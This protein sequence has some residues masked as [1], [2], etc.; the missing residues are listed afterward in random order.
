MKPNDILGYQSKCKSIKN[1]VKAAA[2]NQLFQFYFL[3]EKNN[4]LTQISAGFFFE[5]YISWNNEF[6][7]H[8]SQ[9]L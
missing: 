9:R 6:L 3:K 4:I 1:N 8:L 7:L 2:L 5:Q